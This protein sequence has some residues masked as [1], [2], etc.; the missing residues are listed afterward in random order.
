MTRSSN[1]SHIRLASHFGVDIGEDECR[2]LPCNLGF[3]CYCSAQFMRDTLRTLFEEKQLGTTPYIAVHTVAN[4]T[5]YEGCKMDSWVSGDVGE[6]FG[7]THGE[8]GM[9]QFWV[10][11]VVDLQIGY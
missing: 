1:G 7:C 3:V 9:R 4:N 8:L 2:R 10:V 6:T 11:D 5:I